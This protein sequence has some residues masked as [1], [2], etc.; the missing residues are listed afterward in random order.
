M[1]SAFFDG[2]P[3]TADDLRALAL[4][5]YGHFTSMQMR[6]RAVRGF[7]LHLQRL[8]SA[9]RELFDLRIDDD[10][11][12]GAILAAADAAGVDDASVRVTVCSREFDPARP[13]AS[14]TVDLLVSLSAPREA[15]PTPLRVKTCPFQ[16]ALPR[17]KHVGLFAQLQLRRQALREGFD[18]ALFVDGKGRIS[19][20]STWNIGFWDGAA[21]VWPEAEALRGTTERLLQAGLAEAGIAQRHEVLAPGALQGLK[22]AFAANAAGVRAVS[23]IDATALR[24]DPALMARLAEAL[25]GHRPQPVAAGP[26]WVPPR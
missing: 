4:S 12:R 26:G 22:A 5:N 11:I 10:R 21:V 24:P 23:G 7:D 19:E 14:Q 2:L 25:A 6:A 3:A 9:T 16:R 1:T 18:D 13:G 17:V 20:G 8:K 15:D